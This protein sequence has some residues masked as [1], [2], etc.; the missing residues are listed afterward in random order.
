MPWVKPCEKVSVNSPAFVTD[1]ASAAPD[2][3]FEVG[4]DKFVELAR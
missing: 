3:V 2:K 4:K 1:Y